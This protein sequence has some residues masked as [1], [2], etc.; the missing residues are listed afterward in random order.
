M[1]G[2]DVYPNG[3]WSNRAGGFF[4]QRDVRDFCLWAAAQKI[5]ALKRKITLETNNKNFKQWKNIIK[6]Q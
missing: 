3:E 5:A 6:L 2:A 4:G 1:P